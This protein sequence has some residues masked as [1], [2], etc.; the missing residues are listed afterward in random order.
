MQQSIYV[1]SDPGCIRRH[2][3]FINDDGALVRSRSIPNNVC[4]LPS[5]SLICWV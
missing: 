4:G 3:T 5:L 1:G 2:Q